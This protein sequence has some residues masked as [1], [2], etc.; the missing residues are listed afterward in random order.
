MPPAP[1][2][3]A[4]PCLLGCA[5]ALSGWTLE[6]R[7]G[8]EQTRLCLRHSDAPARSYC[9]DEW[10]DAIANAFTRERMLGIVARPLQ[11]YS[12]LVQ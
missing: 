4:L 9:S 1:A 7:I 6:I 5:L 12:R 11:A 2:A 8:G 3:F 10:V